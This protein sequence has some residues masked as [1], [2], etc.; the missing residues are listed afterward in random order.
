LRTAIHRITG[1]SSTGLWKN[2]HLTRLV[3]KRSILGIAWA[4]RLVGIKQTLLFGAMSER[5]LYRAA[6]ERLEALD[7]ERSE[8]EAFVRTY[9]RLSG[10]AVVDP[11]S[12]KSTTAEIVDAA[13]AVLEKHGRPM[14]LGALYAAVTALGVEI[15]GKI[16]R[17]NFG[18]MLSAEKTRL[19]TSRDGWWFKDEGYPRQLDDEND[20][21]PV[22][23]ATRSCLSNGAAAQPA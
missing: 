20:E 11:P 1:I 14:K 22:A 12:R 15:R 13:L 17:N 9:E 23:S 6:V 10:Q 21:D 2:S 4:P 8:L 5:Q 3:H 7:R 16:P 18:A 19:A